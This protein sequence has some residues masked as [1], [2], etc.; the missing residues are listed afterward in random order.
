MIWVIRLKRAVLAV[1]PPFLFATL[2]LGP[3]L[4]SAHV[5]PKPCDFV[6]GGGFV[7]KDG[8]HA[9]FGL[10]A[11]CKHHH[12]FGHVNFIDHSLEVHV[13]SLNIVSYT[14]IHPGTF[15]RDICGMA[16]TNLFGEMGFHVVVV[17]NGEPG[18]DDRFGLS[19]ATGYMTTT[20]QLAGGNIQLHKPN[21]S[22]T[23][24]ATFTECNRIAPDPGP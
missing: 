9:N 22:T 11:G 18:T 3:S 23:A 5:I 8:S 2:L 6:T 13:A 15:R 14:E 24:P 1:L 17:D 7:M 12:F 10:V 20:R 4:A 19:L 16:E 21:P